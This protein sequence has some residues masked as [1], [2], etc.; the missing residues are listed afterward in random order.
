MSRVQQTQNTTSDE[1]GTTC[2]CAQQDQAGVTSPSGATQEIYPITDDNPGQ[3]AGPCES[4]C[5]E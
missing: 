2:C 5:C 3:P 4:S 1:T